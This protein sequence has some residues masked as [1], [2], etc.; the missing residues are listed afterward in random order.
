[1]QNLSKN[2][3]TICRS[4]FSGLPWAEED[5]CKFSELESADNPL[6]ECLLSFCLP[7]ACNPTIK[8]ETNV[9]SDTKLFLTWFCISKTCVMVRKHF[10]TPKVQEMVLHSPLTYSHQVCKLCQ[11]SAEENLLQ[12]IMAVQK[13]IFSEKYYTAGDSKNALTIQWQTANLDGPLTKIIQFTPTTDRTSCLCSLCE[14]VYCWSRKL[15][16]AKIKPTN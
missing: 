1:M 3:T 9:T 5:I 6:V 2:K 7:K 4:T 10:T 16:K 14:V 13:G 12:I 15:L 8:K 11:A